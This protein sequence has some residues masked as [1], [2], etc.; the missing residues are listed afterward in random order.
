MDAGMI[1]QALDEVFDQAIVYHA[2]TDY[3]RD[4]EV[5]VYAAASPRTDIPP[6]Y[7][8]YLFRCCVAAD[9]RTAL[10]PGIWARSLDERLIDPELAAGLDGYVWGIKW[11]A[12]DPGARLVEDSPRAREWARAI[13]IDFHE[14]RIETNGHDLTLVFSDLEVSELSRGYAPFTVGD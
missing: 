14:V 11:Q 6:A 7:L 5:I 3:L 9:I 13:G 1:R 2:Y 4:Y 10:T 8:R 12:L